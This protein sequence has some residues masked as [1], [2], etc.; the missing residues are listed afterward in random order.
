MRAARFLEVPDIYE[1]DLDSYNRLEEFMDSFSQLDDLAIRYGFSDLAVHG[2]FRTIQVMTAL[3]LTKDSSRRADALDQNGHMVEIK[4][5]DITKS[6]SFSTATELTSEKCRRFRTFM[7]TFGVFVGLRL[8]E[9]YVMDPR[10]LEPLF[11]HFEA[12]IEKS[13]TGFIRNP[14]IPVSYVIKHGTKKFENTN[15]Q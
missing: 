15:S 3:G 8:R 11:L 13:K 9:V 5:C 1:P 4:T 12:K 10:Y 2:N 6:N 7:W 14:S